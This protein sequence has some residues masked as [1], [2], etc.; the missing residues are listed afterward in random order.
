MRQKA[1][2]VILALTLCI[3]SC[4]RP[5]LIAT[6]TPTVVLIVRHAEK[7]DA[8]DD[9]GINEAGAR[10]AQ[11]LL[12]VAEASGV[13]TIYS[14]QYR[15][16]RE[17]AQPVSNRLNIQLSEMPV[18]LD[19]PGNYGILLARDVLE[20]HAGQT[21]LVVSHSNVIPTII[22]ALTQTKVPAIDSNEYDHLF[23]V[24]VPKEGPPRLIKAQ[25]GETK[26]LK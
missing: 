6:P 5:Q 12:D 21:V 26:A 17:T 11:A 9:P 4:N 10:R 20:K 14:S 1:I 22:E 15:R 25:Y 3:V 23:I 16:T 13:S 18:S 19:N 24:I 8:G 7:E 2:I